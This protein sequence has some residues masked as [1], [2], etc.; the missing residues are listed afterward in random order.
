MK[1]YDQ[2]PNNVKA[3]IDKAGGLEEYRLQMKE[4]RSLVKSP[5]RNGYFSIL[6]KEGRI[7][8]LRAL[9]A[10]RKKEKE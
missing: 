8:E 10:N 1:E 9:Q 6:K 5:G 3:A 7:D 4:R 2:Y